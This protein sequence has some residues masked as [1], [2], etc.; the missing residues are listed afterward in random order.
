MSKDLH[1]ELWRHRERR[2]WASHLVGKA[3]EHIMAG[4]PELIQASFSEDL[5]ATSESRDAYAVGGLQ[6][7]LIET[8][9]FIEICSGPNASPTKACLA[10]GLRC[11][12]RLDM[13]LHGVWDIKL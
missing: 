2:G 7:T 11:W 5:I 3:A 8:W 13:L 12:P 10:A 4:A 6:R 9:D 1:R